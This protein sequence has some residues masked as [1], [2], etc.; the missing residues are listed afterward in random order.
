[1]GKYWTG[2]HTKHRLQYHLVWIPKYRK[3][4]LLGKVAIRLKQLLYE[5]ARVNRWLIRELNIQRD[6]VHLLLQIGPN[7]S[8]A[9]AVQRLKGG[10][11]FM[12]R[13]EFPE[14]EEFLWGESFWADG[15][16][17]ES[18]GTAQEDIIRKY[19]REQQKDQSMPRP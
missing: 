3:R 6:H 12:L 15:Y 16:F 13:K 10:T 4:V 17:A 18:V 19:I 11:S 5:A 1:M 2:A 14:L 9:Q 7:V 8:V